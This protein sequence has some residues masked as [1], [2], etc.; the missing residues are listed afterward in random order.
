MIQYF[1]IQ[2]ITYFSIRIIYYYY[3]LKFKCLVN[4]FVTYKIQV[5]FKRHETNNIANYC[6]ALT[7]FIFLPT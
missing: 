4:I 5:K 7:F 2:T 3:N 1:Q 6:L